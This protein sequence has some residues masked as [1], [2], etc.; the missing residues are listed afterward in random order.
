MFSNLIRIQATLV[1]AIIAFVV[2]LFVVY[3]GFM[4]RYFVLFFDGTFEMF[5]Y[6]KQLQ[7]FN[8][9]AFNIVLLFI[10]MAGL[11]YLFGL[12]NYRPGLASLAATIGTTVFVM[13]RSLALLNVLPIYKRSYL[14]LDF[15]QLEDYVPTTFVFDA[16][17]LLH[18]LL[19]G[20][21]VLLTIV[22]IASFIQR[23]RE[24][25]PL[26]RRLQ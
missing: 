16:A 13:L 23:L 25:H 2:S 3:L 6:Y 24:G 7:V 22:S 1:Y 11:L 4:T 19:I 15:T 18:Y 8:K 21:F 10:V 14:A 26:I 17:I 20:S 5:E 12:S 9:E